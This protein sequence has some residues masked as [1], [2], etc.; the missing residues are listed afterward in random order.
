[1]TTAA[2]SVQLSATHNF[3][4]DYKKTL[5]SPMEYYNV[6]VYAFLLSL[7][8]IILLNSWLLIRAMFTFV[9]L[10]KTKND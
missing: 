2:L 10:K 1:M 5:E 7:S 6:D 9:T 4:S 8:I 3:L